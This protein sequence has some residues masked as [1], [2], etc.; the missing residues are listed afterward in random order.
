MS[1]PAPPPL[2]DAVA[3]LAA[4]PAPAAPLG[5]ASPREVRPKVWLY[6]V[7]V[8]CWVVPLVIGVAALALYALTFWDWLPVLGFA[9]FMGGGVLCVVGLICVAVF[10]VMLRP[11]D[12]ALRRAWSPRAARTATLLVANV[13]VAVVCAAAGIDLLSQWRVTLVNATGAPITDITLT[14]PGEVATVGRL[15]PGEDRDVFLSIGGDGE[16]TFAATQDGQPVGGVV[17]GYVSDGM[18]GKSTLTFNPAGAPPTVE[19]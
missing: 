10:Y 2:P 17:V 9:V 8:F 4:A 7:A 12:P 5:Y 19:R 3:A 16:I 13:P 6:R 1:E 18:G 11:A 14:S 15:E